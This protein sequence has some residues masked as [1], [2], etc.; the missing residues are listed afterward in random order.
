M[1]APL[2]TY[3]VSLSS[4]DVWE[5]SIDA[6]T[7]DDA[8]AEALRRYNADGSQD[9][10]H[11]NCGVEDI[12]QAELEGPAEQQHLPLIEAMQQ[13]G[14]LEIVHIGDKKGGAA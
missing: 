6:A 9:F 13:A 11:R 7:E 2:N 4:W 14:R 1:S 10:R 3:R 12:G 8:I 5:I